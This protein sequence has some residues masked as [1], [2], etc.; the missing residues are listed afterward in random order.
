MCTNA[1][2][3]LL[4]A[5]GLLSVALAASAITPLVA[6]VPSPQPD[7]WSTFKIVN[8]LASETK[9]FGVNVTD[10]QIWIVLH[11]SPGSVTYENLAGQTE[12]LQQGGWVQ[13]SQITDGKF[14][15]PTGSSNG[16]MYA[17]IYGGDSHPPSEPVPVPG[18]GVTSDYAYAALEWDFTTAG[19]QNVDAQVIDQFSFPIRI[20]VTDPNGAIQGR[21]SFKEGTNA[22]VILNTIENT[23]TSHASGSLCIYPSPLSNY[24]PYPPGCFS[25]QPPPQSSHACHG[26]PVDY[27]TAP[28]GQMNRSIQKIAVHTNLQ[29]TSTPF[30]WI[31][32]SKGTPNTISGLFTDVLQ[33]FGSSFETSLEALYNGAPNSAD[34]YYMDYDGN[35]GYSFYMKVT[36]PTEN[37]Y[38]GLVFSNIRINTNTSPASFLVDKSAGTA[39]GSSVTVNILANGA[40]ILDHTSSCNTTP[41]N[42]YGLWTD[43]VIASGASPDCDGLFGSGPV[44]TTNMTNHTNPENQS[45]IATMIATVSTALNFGIVSPAWDPQNGDKGTSYIFQNVTPENQSDYLFQANASRDIWAATLWPYQ[46][47]SQIPGSNSVYSRPIYLSTFL[48]RLQNMSPD[49]MLPVLHS[50]GSTVT[51]DIGMPAATPTCP[52]DFDSDGD[53]DGADLSAM[54]AHWGEVPDGQTLPHDLNSDNRIDGADLAIF[55]GQ[56]GTWTEGCP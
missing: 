45:L 35:N 27:L 47:M 37:G 11:S 36:A 53:V 50:P 42:K 39:L 9:Y 51:W 10:D 7:A 8:N 6:A 28:A 19:E 56:W 49:L 21:S 23:Y 54:L 4:S 1:C 41:F 14:S 2:S 52:A 30:R 33:L 25:T 55:L 12:T 38:H 29:T 32:S 13:L 18:G 24:P 3:D 46:D 17:V 20:T 44:I 15:I 26:L 31:G 22:E 43:Q 48:D 5:A 16:A 40:A 34:G